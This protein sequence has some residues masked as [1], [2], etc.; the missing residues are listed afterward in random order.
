MKF[1]LHIHSQYSGD[2]KSKPREIVKIAEKKGLDGL[3]ILDHN[4]IKGYNEIKDMDTDLILVPGI[5]VSTEE[6]HVGAL[7]LKDEIGRPKTVEEAVDIIHEH[8]AIAVAVHPYR[9]WS[10]MGEDVIRGNDWDAMEGMNGR[11]W[12]Y[13]NIRSKK[14]AKEMNLPIIGGSDAH[15]LKS[16]GKAYTIVDNANSWQELISDIKEYKTDVRGQSRTYP[17]TF[18][19]VRRAVGGWIKRG[20]KKI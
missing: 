7:G 11:T 10:G 16:V 9:F 3:A 2:S 8:D 19:Y 1:D 15:R 13:K 5:E 17:Q 14:L 12:G 18:F 20:F 4:T 6:G